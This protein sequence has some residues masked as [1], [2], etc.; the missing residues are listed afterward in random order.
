MSIAFETS[1]QVRFAHIDAAGIV[2]YPRYLEMLNGAV[3]DWCERALGVSFREMH[4]DRKI[5][6]PTVKLQVDFTAPSHLGDHLSIALT[7][8]KLG[9]SSCN[10][11]ICFAC[12]GEV[13]LKAE[14]VLVCMDLESQ[15]STAWPDDM[16]LRISEA[17]TL[18]A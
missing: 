6:V 14:V 2:F 18:A 7:P 4:H 11:D 9:R 1:A 8:K 12:E 5:G 13:R 16:R 10:L 3:E 17:S 15:R